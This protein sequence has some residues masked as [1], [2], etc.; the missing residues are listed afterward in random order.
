M[1]SE[2][3]FHDTVFNVGVHKCYVTALD[4]Q[5]LISQREFNTLELSSVVLRRVF[6]T[7]RQ[8][9]VMSYDVLVRSSH[10]TRVSEGHVS[11][12]HVLFSSQGTL[13]NR[14]APPLPGTGTLSI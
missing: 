14:G 11:K 1:I 9:V 6:N 4:L 5:S 13:G 12:K 8:K 2:V 7:A 3:R 10:F